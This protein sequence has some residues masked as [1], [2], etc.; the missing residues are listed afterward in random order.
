MP[1]VN[2]GKYIF[3]KEIAKE[4]ISKFYQTAKV[5]THCAQ[6]QDVQPPSG[7]LTSVSRLMVAGAVRL[8]VII[9]RRRQQPL[10]RVCAGLLAAVS[11]VSALIAAAILLSRLLHSSRRAHGSPLT[12]RPRSRRRGR[13][14]ATAPPR[15]RARS[16]RR[17]RRGRTCTP[18][19]HSR[20][21][22][23]RRA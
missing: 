22:W 3:G 16:S 13:R 4:I 2:H 14:G 7:V 8:R 6:P 18:A 5:A 15:P 1:F 9:M 23:R 21:S 12:L 17:A 19:T 11:L 10:A 20:A